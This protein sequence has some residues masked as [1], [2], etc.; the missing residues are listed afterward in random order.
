M[1]AALFCA[2]RLDCL[3]H[4]LESF[5]TLTGLPCEEV[6]I[7]LHKSFVGLLFFPVPS[8]TRCFLA[9]LLPVVAHQ[10]KID[11]IV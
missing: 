11:D 4:S 2:P 8:P 6:R 5:E 10:L 3:G 7:S 9:G 1:T